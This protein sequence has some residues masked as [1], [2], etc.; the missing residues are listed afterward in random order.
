MFTSKRFFVTTLALA[1]LLAL[2]LPAIGTAQDLGSARGNLS[3]IVYDPTRAVVP[4]AEVTITGPI[5]SKTQTTNE[6]GTFLFQTLIPGMYNIRVQ[7]AGFRI[8][9]VKNSEVLINKTTSLEVVLQTG[10]LTQVVEVSA[11]SLTLD[12]TSSAVNTNIS[13]S[14]YQNLPVGRNMGSLFYLSPGAVDGQG[15]G[16]NNPSISGSTGL[17]NA[18]VADGV[19]INDPAFGGLGVF[20][21]V[22]GALGTGINLSFVQEV[23]V[24]TGGFEPQYGHAA[25][26]V[27]QVVTKSGG[28]E[29]HGTIG[30]YYGGK[31]MQTQFANADDLGVVNQF[32]KWLTISRYEGDFELGGYVPLHALKDKLFYFGTFNPTWVNNYDSPGTNS[33][34]FALTNGKALLKQTS[35]DYAGKLT[36][37][38][39]NVHTLESSVFGDPSHTNTGPWTTLTA[40]N[41]TT[42]SKWNY[43]TRNWAVRYDGTI[44]SSWLVDA[45]FT[46]SWNHFAET[47]QSDVVQILDQTQTQNLPGQAGQFT[48]Q[49]FGYNEPYDSNTR[50]ISA[51]TS[52]TVHILGQAHTFSF[53][54]TWQFPVYNDIIKESGGYFT[55]PSA[56]A[57]GGNPGYLNNAAQPA[58]KK[59]DAALTL[60]LAGTVAP[61]TDGLFD[62]K[63][64]PTDTS[65]TL[66]P[67]MSIPGYSEPVPVVLQQVRGRFDGGTTRSSGKYHAAYINDAWSMGKHVTLNLGVRWE[68]QRLIGNI[69]NKLF[70]DMWSPRIGLTVDPK[71]DRKSKI[72]ANF[73][74]YHFIL[75][76]DAAVRELSNEEDFLNP[77]WA[78]A[79]TTSGCPTGT[80]SGASCVVTAGGAPDYAN[81]FVPDAAHL[82]SK[83]T[84]GVDIAP[85]IA[86]NGGE[87]YQPGLRAEYTDEFVVGAEHQFRGGVLASVRYIDRRL[88]RVVEDEGGISVEQFIALAANGGGLN[89]FIGNPNSQADI[90]VNPN[91]LTFSLGS[92][93]T[94]PTDSEG[95]PLPLTKA[96]E[97]LYL[98]AGMPQGCFDSN[99][100]GTPYV[101]YNVLKPTF[102]QTPAGSACFPAVNT[103]T[104][105]DSSGNLLPDCTSLAQSKAGGCAAF[106]GEFYPDGKPDTYKN[107]E[108]IYQAIEFEVNK[109]FSHNWALVANWRVARLTGNYEGA[110]R[111]DNGQADP[112]ISSLFDLTEGAFGL[113]GAQQGIGP[114]NTDRKHVINVYT[115]YVLD[116][117]KM[118][119][120]TLGSGVR[121]QSGVPLTTLY[122]QYAYQNAGEVP[123]FGRGDL[124]RAPTTGTVDLHAEYPWKL[125]EKMSLKIGFDAFNVANTKRY[126]LVNEFGDLGF[127]QQNL[128]F[129]KPGGM[130]TFTPGPVWGHSFVNPFNSRFSLKLVF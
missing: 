9:D 115:T 85:T 83:A 56:N 97:A 54:Y 48:A 87:P 80:P 99:G 73:G 116:R 121:I 107:P 102:P 41:L 11:A 58:G 15:T 120:L 13:E 51:D 67:Y 10:E 64:N 36:Y 108:R 125:T 8:S 129:Q 25:G 37:K 40:S 12:T 130:Q 112:G 22:H 42:N 65:C 95:N 86:I 50:S 7:K 76:L 68:Q 105:T 45:A 60:I 20:S 113:L 74:R 53:G 29:T 46:W 38:I 75:P 44:G 49:G 61:G 63:N 122:A 23:Q 59:S 35:W 43:G 110:F 103:G 100:N 3:G 69:T 114:L 118:K 94:P 79:S 17:E 72:Y 88:K 30:G 90:F 126:T 52:K 111:N 78:P 18:Y 16:Y 62:P 2:T 104:W 5:G 55:I 123:W 24:K 81:M 39:N 89:Y 96:N 124:G 1:L 106:G 34:L 57:T 26:G 98:A 82:L 84:G 101:A 31:W 119:G 19:N 4:G 109:S 117:T 77:Y 6:T 91:E 70:N 28:T 27:V 32:G 66:C 93:F 92:T 71:G 47:P 127:G 33:G 128:D 14:L 21:R